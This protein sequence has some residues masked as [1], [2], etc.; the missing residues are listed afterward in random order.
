MSPPESPSSAVTATSF[1]EP[2]T[3]CQNG[4]VLYGTAHNCAHSLVSFNSNITSMLSSGNQYH[5]HFT[6]KKTEAQRSNTDL[7]SSPSWSTPQRGFEP[8]SAWLHLCQNYHFHELPDRQSQSKNN[9]TWR[10]LHPWQGEIVNF[11]LSF[12]NSWCF[13]AWYPGQAAGHKHSA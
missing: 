3:K 10:L 1:H 12:L 11:K 8:A 13:L 2:P 7:T 9:A 6:D 4:T 5:P